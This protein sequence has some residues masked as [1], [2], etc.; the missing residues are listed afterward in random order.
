M[1][2]ETLVELPRDDGSYRWRS[3]EIGQASNL[4]WK[5]GR[6]E[7]MELHYEELCVFLSTH[8][9]ALLIGAENPVASPDMSIAT[10]RATLTEDGVTAAKKFFHI[11]VMNVRRPALA[12]IR[13]ITDM[14]GALAWRALITRYAPISLLHSALRF[15]LL[16]CLIPPTWRMFVPFRKLVWPFCRTGSAHIFCMDVSYPSDIDSADNDW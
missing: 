13:G 3:A 1:C 4:Q 9:P 16:L 10:I 5:G 8:V 12:V 2:L 11:L 15:L 14:N 7:R 6:V